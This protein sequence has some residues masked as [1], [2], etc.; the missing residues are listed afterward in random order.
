DLQ[1]DFV[2]DDQP[3]ILLND[4]F[5][6]WSNWKLLFTSHISSSTNLAMTYPGS[7]AIHYRPLYMLWLMTISKLSGV[8]TP[9]FHFSSLLLHVVVIFL[10]YWLAQRL[11]R[12]SW[13]AALAAILFA[14]HPI[15]VEPV[16]YIS[17][18]TDLLATFFLLI[19][20]LCY[21]RFRQDSG[22]LWL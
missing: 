22:P 10:V 11:L 19:S 18:S 9:W 12:D 6:S 1:Y 8:S 13:P 7:P 17:A 20:V 3:L 5:N 2:L 16:A 4:T 15:H 21:L 14:F